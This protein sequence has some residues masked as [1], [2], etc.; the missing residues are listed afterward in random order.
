MRKKKSS[1]P[2]AKRFA[3][4]YPAIPTPIKNK[5]IDRSGPYLYVLSAILWTSGLATTE[6]NKFSNEASIPIMRSDD[7][8][9]TP[10]VYE[11][12]GNRKKGKG[13][14]VMKTYP[15]PSFAK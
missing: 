5:P 4:A 3:R 14:N 6:N 1:V 13:Y 9:E 12:R 15:F 11:V 8:L 7:T 10:N 2:D